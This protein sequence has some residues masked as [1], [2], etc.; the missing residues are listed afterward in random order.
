MAEFTPREIKIIQ[1]M[2]VLRNPHLSHAPPEL[3]KTL[4][5]T[6]LQICGIQFD[7]TEIIDIANG[8]TAEINETVNKSLGVFNRLAPHMKGIDLSKLRL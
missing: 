2:N 3:K 5:V 4:L 7:E 6:Q 8:I 1:T